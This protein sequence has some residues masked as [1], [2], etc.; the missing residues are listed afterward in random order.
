MSDDFDSVIVG[1]DFAELLDVSIN[2]AE[3]VKLMLPPRD[4][5][6]GVEAAYLIR[7]IPRSH[8]ADDEGKRSSEESGEVSFHGQGFRRRRVSE[9]PNSDTL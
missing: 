4:V 5:D 1:G 7:S 3:D 2:R 9:V 6:V 8:D